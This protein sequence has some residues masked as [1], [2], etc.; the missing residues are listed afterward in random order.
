MKTIFTIGTRGMHDEPFL[1]LLHEHDVDAVIDVRLRNRGRYY[2]FAHRDHI[3][4][5]LDRHGIAY[6]HELLFAPA[7]RTLLAYRTTGNW[8]EYVAAFNKLINER[9]MAAVW[10]ARYAAFHNPCLLCAEETPEE[11]HRRLLAE[12]FSTE[13]SAPIIHLSRG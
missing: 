8:P 4:G 10:K 13:F 5:L 9:D 1:R 2:V 12:H 6:A 3:Q 7:D 11:C